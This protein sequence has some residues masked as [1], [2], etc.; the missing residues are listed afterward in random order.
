MG[1]QIENIPPNKTIFFFQTIPMWGGRGLVKN[2]NTPVFLKQAPLL[3]PELRPGP[4]RLL[5][6]SLSHHTGCFIVIFENLDT[7]QS[8]YLEI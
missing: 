4:R 1:E 7:L 5:E 6:F 3:G 8:I 2:Q